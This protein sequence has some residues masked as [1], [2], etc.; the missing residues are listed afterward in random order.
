[1]NGET[2]MSTVSP[3]LGGKTDGSANALEDDGREGRGLLVEGTDMVGG[4]Q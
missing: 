4:Q 3:P 2:A 1:M